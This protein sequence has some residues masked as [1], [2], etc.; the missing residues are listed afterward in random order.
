M[1]GLARA[2]IE[3]DKDACVVAV[4]LRNAFNSVKREA[5]V[6]A[7]KD[8]LLIVY[9]QWAYGTHSQLRFG[10]VILNSATG[11]QHGDP[12]GHVL[13]A[14]SLDKSSIG[15]GDTSSK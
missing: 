2:V 4:D 7:V 14:F 9:T 6:Q 8:N 3:S 1:V 15:M 10:N 13:F 11:V 5:V 12:A